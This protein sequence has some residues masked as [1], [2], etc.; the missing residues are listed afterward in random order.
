MRLFKN[1]KCRIQWRTI[2]YI[3]LSDSLKYYY[4]VV[5][6]FADYKYKVGMLKFKMEQ[7]KVEEFNNILNF[8]ILTLYLQSATSKTPEQKDSGESDKFL[9]NRPPY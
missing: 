3:N 8:D 1:L 5:F 6:G 2:F 7:E 4:S 9:K